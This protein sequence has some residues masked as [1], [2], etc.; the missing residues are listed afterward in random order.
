VGFSYGTVIGATY[1]NLFPDKVRAMVLD[2]TL[3][4]VGNAT[5]HRPGDGAA[6]PVDVRQ[7]VDR[8]GQEVFLDASCRCVRRPGARAR[9]PP[10][11]TSGRNAG[12]CWRGRRPAS[13]P[14]RT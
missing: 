2:G 4:F 5:G 1:A 12:P 3:D 6:F 7:G 13:S 8:A 11:G 9:S 10:A 14:T